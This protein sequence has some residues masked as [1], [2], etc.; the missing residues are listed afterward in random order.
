MLI[1]TPFQ[2]SAGNAGGFRI[3]SLK[4]SPT[5]TGLIAAYELFEPQNIER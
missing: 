1:H 3:A 2:L 4:R 5:A